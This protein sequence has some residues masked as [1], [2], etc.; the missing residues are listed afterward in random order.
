MWSTTRPEPD[1]KRF[2]IVPAAPEQK[3]E[4]EQ[5]NLLSKP[6]FYSDVLL[7]VCLLVGFYIECHRSRF[8]LT[9]L[10]LSDVSLCSE[11]IQCS[12]AL[13]FCRFV[14]LNQILRRGRIQEL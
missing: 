13:Y 11:L 5:N 14:F 2:W 3:P 7:K 6:A 4:P 12:E 10:V 1:L 9:V 8:A